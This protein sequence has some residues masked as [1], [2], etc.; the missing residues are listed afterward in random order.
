MVDR[1]LGG[2]KVGLGDVRYGRIVEGNVKSS[3]RNEE[4][5]I[6][7]KKSMEIGKTCG[8]LFSQRINYFLISLYQIQWSLRKK[9]LLFSET[10]LNL[11]KCSL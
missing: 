9:I 2:R 6:R 7:V 8:R 3:V 10:P 4:R 1:G 11:V 5:K